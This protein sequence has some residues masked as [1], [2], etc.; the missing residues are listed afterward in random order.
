M[1]VLLINNYPMDHAWELWNQ[2]EY[3]AHHLWGATHLHKYGID[4]DILP[5]EKYL[6]LK[7]ISRKTKLLGDLDQQLR[8]LFIKDLDKYDVIYSAC[9]LNTSLLAFL[10]S[11]GIF[12]IPVIAVMHRRFKENFL[13]KV[14]FNTFMKNHDHFLCLSSTI[15]D[16]LNSSFNIPETKL[17]VIQWGMDLQFYQLNSESRNELI[18]ND[19]TGFIV[20]AGKTYRDYNTL[21]KAFKEIKCNL[22][23]Y[24]AGNTTVSIPD[25]PSNVIIYNQQLPFEQLI[26][27]YE[28]AYAIAI[29]LDIS[30]KN[31]QTVTQIG[32]TSL[33]EAMVMGKA[34]VMTRNR[35]I[36][37]DIQKEGIG[38][39][40]E[41]GDVE[42]WKQAIFYLLEHPQETKEMG[43]R[44]RCLCESTYS[45][46]IFVSNLAN[47]F[48]L[49][50][51]NQEL[52]KV[53]Q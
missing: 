28:K 1:K 13:T 3:P 44:A 34:V 47:I 49:V 18:I 19:E 40:V 37:I 35:Q 20:S 43:K 22:E 6:I 7:K 24:G 38:I 52:V 51:E 33:L 39:F 25:I 15:R 14:W 21:Q 42:G 30:S 29:P 46:E 10:R 26:K 31:A 12:N 48:K 23:I 16:S 36:D 4:V 41:P 11:I 8:I 53:N 27:K 5:H 2:K 32:L 50:L 45:F 9:D 17:S